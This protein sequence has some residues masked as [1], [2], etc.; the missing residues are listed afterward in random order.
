[1]YQSMN[2]LILEQLWLYYTS[3]CH[4]LITSG[5]TV[6]AKQLP[7]KNLGVIIICWGSQDRPNVNVEFVAFHISKTK[8]D[9]VTYMERL[10]SQHANRGQEP[11]VH[12][13]L[14]SWHTSRV[15]DTNFLS[16]QSTRSPNSS[17]VSE[18]LPKCLAIK[19]FIANI[20]CLRILIWN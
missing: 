4:L 1:M 17:L 16:H 10:D 18:L 14:N 5:R 7:K 3:Q 19:N 9:T 12:C 20:Y 13:T 6:P 2:K 11:T 8:D 15:Y